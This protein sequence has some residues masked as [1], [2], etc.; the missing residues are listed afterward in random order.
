[1]G[2]HLALWSVDTRVYLSVGLSVPMK[3]YKKAAMM[4]Y[5]SATKMVS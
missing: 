3:A 5:C 4:V 1:M 2:V